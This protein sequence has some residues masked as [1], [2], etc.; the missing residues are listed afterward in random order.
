MTRCFLGMAT[1]KS[2]AAAKFDDPSVGGVVAD[3]CD[4][5]EQVRAI[6]KGTPVS[7]GLTHSV[8]RR[9][10]SSSGSYWD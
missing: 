6:D 1:F 5:V 8:R 2:S 10:S 9:S 7:A 3:C 4:C